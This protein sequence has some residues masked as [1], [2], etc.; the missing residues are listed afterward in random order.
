MK[1][2]LRF[3]LLTLLKRLTVFSKPMPFKK[4]KDFSTK[5]SKTD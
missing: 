4:G 2:E 3:A 5:I 1:S